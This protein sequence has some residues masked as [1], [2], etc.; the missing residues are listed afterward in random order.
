MSVR[1]ATCKFINDLNRENDERVRE[2]E[3]DRE[4]TAIGRERTVNRISLFK[5]GCARNHFPSRP[6]CVSFRPLITA[7]MES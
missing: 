2:R 6:S 5:T 1:A 3:N 4:D 7:I